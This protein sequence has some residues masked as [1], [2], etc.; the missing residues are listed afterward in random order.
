M[1]KNSLKENLI[2]Q[3][4]LKGFTQE[5][6]S[7]R[8]SVTVRTIQR[9]EKGEVSPHL[10]TVKLLAVGLGVEVE[11]L[12]V[13][14]NPKEETVQRKWMLLLHG[15]PF[16]GLIIP[17]A[18]I[19]FPLFVWM[20]KANDNKIYDT[21]GRAIINFHC[22]ISLLIIAS[23]LL[24]FLIPGY[25]FIITA[26]VALFGIVFSIRSLF[27]SLDTGEFYFPL[28]ISFLKPKSA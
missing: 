13:L 5:E 27:S 1:K 23:L 19:L 8:T 22:T 18:N 3:R 17:F 12:M 9:I 10:Q 16:F 6:L 11:D 2:Y 26:G 15:S 28:S 25:N 21:H 7:D 14:H 4:K 20:G 24:F